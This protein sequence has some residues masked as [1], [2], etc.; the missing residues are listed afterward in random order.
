M[1][2]AGPHFSP[3]TM[4]GGPLPEAQK[5]NDLPWTVGTLVVPTAKKSGNSIVALALYKKGKR[6]CFCLSVLT[7]SPLAA[8]LD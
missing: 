1:L 5:L 2:C 3:V 4:N 8:Q 7:W 6:S